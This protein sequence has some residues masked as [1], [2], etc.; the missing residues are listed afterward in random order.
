M[1]KKTAAENII[2]TN[3]TDVA[4]IYD[5]RMG[6]L[7]QNRRQKLKL[8]SARTRPVP[9][10]LPLLGSMVPMQ[11]F[12]EHFTSPRNLATLVFNRKFAVGFWDSFVLTSK[13]LFSVS[14]S[15]TLHSHIYITRLNTMKQPTFY[16]KIVKQ[17]THAHSYQDELY[18]FAY[19]PLKGVRGWG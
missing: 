14:L 16:I 9:A 6:W 1:Y 10:L 17:N 18:V 13:L 15:S 8:G 19:G 3:S 5:S 11:F 7:L 12:K 4:A 2:V